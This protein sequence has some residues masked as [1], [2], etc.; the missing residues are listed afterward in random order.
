V[1]PSIGSTLCIAAFGEITN[2]MKKPHTSDH[3][4][5]DSITSFRRR[6]YEPAVDGRSVFHN[7]ADAPI[8]SHDQV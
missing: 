6:C 7:Q 1:N 8:D 3:Q 4:L 5:L 2:L